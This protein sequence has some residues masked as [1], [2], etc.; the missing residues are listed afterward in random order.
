MPLAPEYLHLVYPGVEFHALLYGR[1]SRDPKKKGRSVEAQLAEGRELADTHH[2][3]VIEEFKDPGLS[4]SRHR[5]RERD[6]FEALLDAI[7]YGPAV[8]GVIRV[9]VAYEASRYYRDLEAYVRLRNAC[10]NAGVLLCY[11]GTVYDL[12]KREDRKATAMDAIA[13][14]DEVEG[15]R[16]RNLRTA[17][18]TAQKGA[19]WGKIPFGYR[20]KYDPDT[21]DLIGQFE[22]PKQGPVVLHCFT[23]VDG[24]GSINSLVK[25]LKGNADAERPDGAEWNDGLVRY[26]L[27]NKVYLGERLH[28]GSSV[29]ATW[30]PIKGLHN[31][32]GRALFR[33]VAKILNDPARGG[34]YDSRVKHWLSFEALCGECGDDHYMKG[35]QIG[36]NA[37]R[38]VRHVYRCKDGR[39][40]TITERTLDA[41]VEEALLTW[42]SRK[43]QARAAL[44]P[45]QKEKAAELAQAQEQLDL[46]QEELAEARRLNQTRSADGRPLLSLTSLSA[47]ELELLPLIE[48]LE[49][50]V[51]AAT[52]VPLLVQKLLNAADPEELWNGSETAEGL[53][54][55]QKREALRHIV[56]VR[57]YKTRPGSPRITPERV[58]LS[59]VGTPGFK[60]PRS[61]GQSRASVPA[62][63]RG[64]RAAAPGGARGTV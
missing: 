9:C 27:L 36:A 28:N 62:Q 55:E 53:S 7:E 63:A 45:D 14:E 22:H 6:E 1:N 54:I 21:G 47:K 5:R 48:K 34:R 58:R 29:K 8:D 59:F 33:R 44:L 30:E 26:M 12:S 50:K 23:H 13:A 37:T 40:V 38:P 10:F 24:G 31:A 51:Q 64:P 35:D 42:L 60:A 43:E 61:R 19:P 32:E 39:D 18:Q 4:A 11:N 20:R 41:Y 25:W 56:T 2:W 46:Y 57:I 3:P 15:I 17:R 52:G 16:D 49:E